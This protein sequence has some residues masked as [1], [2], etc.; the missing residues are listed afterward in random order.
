MKRNKP[1]FDVQ[2]PVTVEWDTNEYYDGKIYDVTEKIGQARMYGVKFNDGDTGYFLTQEIKKK[3]SIG[4][5][6]LSQ[7]YSLKNI[8]ELSRISFSVHRGLIGN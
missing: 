4:A 6:P 5:D 1:T 7:Q 8:I 3:N 2:D